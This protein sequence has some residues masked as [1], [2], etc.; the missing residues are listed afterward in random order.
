MVALLNQPRQHKDILKELM[1]ELQLLQVLWAESHHLHHSPLDKGRLRD[2]KLDSK[3]TL[4]PPVV[5]DSPRSTINLRE[6]RFGQVLDLL[7]DPPKLILC[8]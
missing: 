6:C 3:V 1:A 2:T 8:N 4:I 7:S 5:L